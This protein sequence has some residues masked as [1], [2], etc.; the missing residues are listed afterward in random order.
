MNERESVELPEPTLVDK[1]VS[2]GMWGVGLAWMTPMM[3]TMM[4]GHAVLGPDRI[5]RFSR[6]YTR[7]QIALTGARYETVVHP[8]IDPNRPYLFA[9]NHV[10]VFDHV[11]LYA[12]TPHFKQGVELEDHFKIPVYGWFMKSRGTI[13]V[14]KGS[15]GQTEEILD[16]FRAELDK[17]HSILAFPEGT[18]TT[19]GRVGTF[20][21]GIFYIAQ[22]LQ[23]PIIPVA[24][25]G[26]YEKQRKGSKLLL[27]GGVVTVN[28]EKPIETA[29][30][31]PED[32]PALTEQVQ[33][34]VADKVD[35]Y[36]QGI[37]GGRRA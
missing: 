24:V 20:R 34:V 11:V 16:G 29:D 8:D 37:E 27:P 9:Q 13:P 5:D 28:C 33:R 18:R 7:G 4:L 14:R 17:G 36:W 26:M 23:L 22:A 21:K 31:T 1:A 35:A 3:S 2:V 15:Q 32:V 6:L 10:N 12:A 25:T 30:L 19:T